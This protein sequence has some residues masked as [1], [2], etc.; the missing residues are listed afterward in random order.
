[1]AKKTSLERKAAQAFIDLL[2][3][4]VSS[5]EGKAL[6]VHKRDKGKAKDK[7]CWVTAKEEAEHPPQSGNFFVDVIVTFRVNAFKDGADLE[8]FYA[9]GLAVLKGELDGEPIKLPEELSKLPEFR[10]YGVMRQEPGE[11]RTVAGGRHEEKEVILKIACGE[12]D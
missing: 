4:G 3:R 12:H 5:E 10:C 8:E 9:S 6:Y 1:M 11:D 7:R 2:K